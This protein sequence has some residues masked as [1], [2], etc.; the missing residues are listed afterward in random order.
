MRSDFPEA[1]K[2]WLLAVFT[3]AKC[4]NCDAVWDE[5]QKL[6]ATQPSRVSLV[7]V[8]SPSQKKL[9][10]DYGIEA[11]P[12]TVVADINGEVRACHLGLLS[13]NTLSELAEL[14]ANG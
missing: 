5:T 10:R 1:D 11:V 7:R 9:H 8:D 2:P 12:L 13:P 4:Q 14:V 3:A 6:A